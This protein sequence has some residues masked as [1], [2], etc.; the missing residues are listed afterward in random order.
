MT[1]RRVERERAAVLVELTIVLPLLMMISLAVLD[2]GLGYKANLTISGATRA[3]ARTASNLGIAT[4]T[5]KEALKSLGAAIGS[6]PTAEIDVIVIFRSTSAV[7]T[8]P[9]GC[10]NSTAKANGGDST[11]KCNTY[12][13]TEVAAIVAGAGP[14]FGSGCGTT[15]DRFW[16]PTTR[17]NAQSGLSGPDYV[18]VFIRVNHVTSTKMFGS[19]MV[20]QDTAIMRI[21]PGAG[22]T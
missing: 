5:D 12:T 8:V 1:A 19:T 20:I 13:G 18:G 4:V 17:G 9:A 2:L 15:R 16:C 10:T 6:I 11:L 7:G 21:E 22:N 14:T 3:G